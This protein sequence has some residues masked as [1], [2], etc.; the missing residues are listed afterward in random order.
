MRVSQC[1]E[2]C[3]DIE[4]TTEHVLLQCPRAR[5]IWRRS[6]VLLPAS[7]VTAQD[8]THVL[9]WP[10]RSPRSA[11]AGIL[12]AYLSYH[13]W[14]DRNAG[15][16]EG[17]WSSLRMVVDR[18]SRHAREVIEAT[19]V[20]SSGMARDIWGTLHAALAFRFA[21]VSWVPPPL[22]YL[23]VNFDGSR[24]V[25]GVIGGAG[26]VIRDHLGRML[27]AGGRR[28]PGVTAVGAELRA[29]W[30][31]YSMPGEY[32]VSSGCSSRGTHL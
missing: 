13:I 26:F 1:C 19:A 14:L 24:L 4:E 30:R 32:W 25:D 2:A 20:V 29:A 11:E 6:P 12:I 3:A 9:R 15:L 27:A 5:E 31:V 22:G 10:M 17:R 23:K 28:T 18:A 8:L 21:L 7:V 16:F